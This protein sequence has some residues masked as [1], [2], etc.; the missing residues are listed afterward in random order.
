MKL[1]KKESYLHVEFSD[2]ESYTTSACTDELWKSLAENVD[3]EEEVKK[4]L[5][6]DVPK[7]GRALLKEVEKSNILTLRGNSVYMLDV[8]ELSIPEDFVAKVIE[9][10]KHNDTAEIEKFRNFWTLVSL[11]PDSRVR[12]NLFWFIRK[13]DMKI[14]DSGLI[15][16][17]RNADLRKED[18]YSTR[19]VKEIINA[20]YQEKYVNH[21]DP[22][23]I[24]LAHEGRNKLLKNNSLGEAY[25]DIVNRGNSPV[26]TDHHSHTM[27]IILGQPVTM[28]REECDAD[29]EHSCSRG[30]HCGAKGWLKQNYYGS[31]GMMVLVNPAKVVAVPTIDDYGKMRACEYFPIALVDFDNKGDI[32]EPP[33]SLHNDVAYLKHLKYD[34]K[35]NNEDFDS[36]EVEHGYRSREEMY[37]SILRNLNAS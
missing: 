1:F 24:E 19:D 32:I 7:S 9:A 16:A 27:S 5:L 11:N 2:G 18:Q 10:E 21:N 30:L 37:D 33:Y 25:D 23:K 3:N 8:S 36:Y 12:N 34:G 31:V 26:Y 4:L 14:T 15:I 29:Q 22:Y 20:Y 17:Y 13:W 6:G 28:P 35:V